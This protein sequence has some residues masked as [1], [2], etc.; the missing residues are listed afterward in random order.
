MES[1]L[2]TF[3]S[4]KNSWEQ[5]SRRLRGDTEADWEQPLCGH[6]PNIRAFPP[7]L[8]L[9]G[10]PPLVPHT[11]KLNTRSL[12]A[13]KPVFHQDGNLFPCISGLGPGTSLPGT[14]RLPQAIPSVKASPASEQAQISG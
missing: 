7:A 1:T 2:G 10:L 8:L 3:G 5:I 9:I 4:H 11:L 14:G 12:A 6:R 13:R